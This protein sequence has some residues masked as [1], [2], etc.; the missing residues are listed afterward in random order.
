MSHTVIDVNVIMQQ[1]ALTECDITAYMSTIGKATTF[2]R[3]ERLSAKV[4]IPQKL[5]NL[6]PASPDFK[7]RCKRPYFH[8]ALWKGYDDYAP[9]NHDPQTIC[10]ACDIKGIGSCLNTTKTRHRSNSRIVI[11][12]SCKKCSSSQCS[13]SKYDL[14]C[15]TCCKCMDRT[16]Y[17]TTLDTPIA[18]G[19]QLRV[20][21]LMC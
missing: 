7:R 12:V 9:P 19:L 16:M 6:P 17:K 10:M 21:P 14:T 15:T 1:H 8:T 4:L 11:S 3:Q 2:K 13:C 5:Y 20:G 18:S